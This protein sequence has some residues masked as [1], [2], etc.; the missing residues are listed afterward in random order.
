MVIRK[1]KVNLILPISK[2]CTENIRL[3]SALDKIKLTITNKI[4][5]NLYIL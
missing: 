3:Q 2:K 4:I 1:V 5:I